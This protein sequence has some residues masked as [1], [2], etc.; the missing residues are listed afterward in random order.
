[1]KYSDSSRKVDE[2]I[3]FSG[4]LL[5][6]HYLQLK[7]RTRRHGAIQF[8]STILKLSDDGST[9]SGPFL[10]YGALYTKGWIRG[11]V[12]IERQEL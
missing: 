6:N 7:F 9:L 8:D 4:R 10:G 2:T 11:T 5:F 3:S 12:Q 1:M